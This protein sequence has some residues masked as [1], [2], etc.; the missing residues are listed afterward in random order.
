MRCRFC[1]SLSQR[2]FASLEAATG[3]ARLRFPGCLYPGAFLPSAYLELIFS[4][5]WRKSGFGAAMPHANAPVGRLR[6]PR[7]CG[8]RYPLSRNGLHFSLSQPLFHRFVFFDRLKRS[9]L[10]MKRLRVQ[11]RDYSTTLV[12]TPEPTVR[13]P[14]RMAKRSP[15][16]HAIGVI[17]VISITTLSP[18]MTI[19]TPSGILM[20][21]VTSVVRK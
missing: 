1:G 14:S 2:T 13:P 10:E 18:G 19:S 12:T 4:C 11:L 5:A 15:S 6:E 3:G 9:R 21:P 17:S 7:N 20:L 8:P 16:S